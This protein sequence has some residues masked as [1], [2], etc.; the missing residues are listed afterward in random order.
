[1]KKQVIA[2]GITASVIVTPIT[3]VAAAAMNASYSNVMNYSDKTET[4][5]TMNNLSNNPLEILQDPRYVQLEQQIAIKK[6]ENERIAL[7]KAKQE[8]A[9]KAQKER[10]RI[11]NVK[12][13]SYDIGVPSGITREEMANV[14]SHSHFANFSDLSDAFVDAEKAYGVNA[15]ALVAIPALESG[16]NTSERAHNGNNNIV[17]MNVPKNASRGTVY[18]SKRDC[19]MDLA[20]QLRNYYLTPGAQYYVGPSTSKI[21]QHYSAANDWY[22]QVDAIG[23][24]LMA[25][26]R[27]LYIR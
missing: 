24:E 20:M 13:D 18:R 26:Y 16:W 2:L 5:S 8:E 21:N 23:D 27:N 3:S 1:M 9:L 25:E 4:E 22:K 7:E 15:F 12:F 11:D 19:I 17:G 10:E 6:A 14:L